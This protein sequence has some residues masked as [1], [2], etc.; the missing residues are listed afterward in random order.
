VVGKSETNA[1][2]IIYFNRAA[3]GANASGGADGSAYPDPQQG[4]PIN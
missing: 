3:Q 1:G 2:E 4:V